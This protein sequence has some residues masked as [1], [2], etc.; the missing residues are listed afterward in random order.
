MAQQDLIVL[1]ADGVL[2]DYHEGYARAW[3]RAFGER[4]K[5]RNPDGYHPMDYWDV[6]H[7]TLDEQRKLGRDGFTHDIWM[8]MPAID[9]AVEACRALRIAGYRLICVSAISSRFEMVRALNLENLGIQVEDMIGVGELG[10]SNP[11]ATTL[12]R[13]APVAFVDDYL[14]YLQ[15]LHHETWRALVEGRPHNNPNHDPTLMPAHSRHASL[16]DFAQWWLHRFRPDGKVELPS[17]AL[18]PL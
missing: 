15:G 3:E 1:D 5:V 17:G 12:R 16:K 18:A 8:S 9:G 7:L 4:P 11:K 2:L 14:G 6:K 13:L 10:G